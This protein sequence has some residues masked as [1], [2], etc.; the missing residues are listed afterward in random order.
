MGLEQLHGENII[1]GNQRPEHITI[2]L[3]GTF[4]LT[5][6]ESDK[7]RDA[8]KLLDRKLNQI[9]YLA[10]EQLFG[11]KI[12]SRTDL[13]AL[14]VLFYEILTSESDPSRLKTGRN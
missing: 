10:P 8:K 9:A 12:D 3:D 2:T 6:L 11:Q 4:V 1:H 7:S 5:G 13:Y 14:G